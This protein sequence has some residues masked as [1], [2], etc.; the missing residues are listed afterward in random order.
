MNQS[1]TG[2]PFRPHGALIDA[3][4][5]W[6]EHPANQGLPAST[7]TQL[8]Q[9]LRR[10]WARHGLDSQP[11]LLSIPQLIRQQDPG[12]LAMVTVSAGP[13]TDPLRQT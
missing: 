4:V 6:E 1:T 10:S 9:A 11:R 3:L 7:L 5:F 8:R 2:R 13:S 12:A